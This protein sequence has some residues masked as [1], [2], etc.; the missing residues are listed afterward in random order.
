[1][2]PNR[3]HPVP[4]TSRLRSLT[5]PGLLLALVFVVPPT[6]TAA[7]PRERTQQPAASASVPREKSAA[8]EEAA[9]LQQEADKHIDA[10]QFKDAAEKTKQALALRREH[11]GEM[12][13]AVA[14][15]IGRLAVI[16]Y[17]QADYAGAET[18]A[19]DALRIRVA[20]LGP[21]HLDVAESLSDLASFVLVRGDYVQP[22]N[23]YQRALAIYEKGSDR[24]SSSGSDVPGLTADVLNNLALLYH[25]KGDYDRAESHYLKALAIT[26]STRGKDDP[27]VA[28]TAA[29][30]GGTY[31]ASG[32][33]DKAVE[34]LERALAIQEKHL[35]ANHPSL[36]TSHFN[37]AAVYFD[38][39]DYAKA[40]AL[41]RRALAIDE[42]TLDARHPRLAIRLVGLAEVLRLQ[43]QYAAADALYQRA[44]TIREQALGPSHPQVAETLIARS[45]L[46][47]ATGD[48][49]EAAEWLTRGATIR[50]ENL[51]LVLT[52]GSE[53]AKRLYVQ[54]LVDETD[55]AL[56]LHLKAAPTSATAAALALTNL[57]QRKGRSMDAMANQL[58]AVRGRLDDQDREVLGQLSRAQG[59]LATLVLGRIATDEQ[60]Q[61]ESSLRSQI[62]RLEGTIS[63][64]SVEFRTASRKATVTDIQKALPPAT[65]LIEFVSY[66]PFSVK[67]ARG[68]TF[69]AP[70]YAV[71]V[72]G[73][74]GLVASADLGEADEIEQEV[75]RF[76]ASLS[77]PRNQDVREA[78]RTLHRRL[79]D[80]ILSSLR[81]ADRILIA[82]DGALNLIPFAALLDDDG[83][84]LVEKYV[85]SYLTSGRD[86]LRLRET[87]TRAVRSLDPPTVLAN[88]LF[89]GLRVGP[90]SPEDQRPT[91]RG[92]PAGLLDRLQF[93]ALP[94]TADE[95]SA[96]A[97]VLTEARVY[98]GAS[99]T[100]LVLKQA[101]A[102]SILH[103][104]THGFFLRPSGGSQA[105]QSSQ[106]SA[107][108]RA[109]RQA[110]S[111]EDALLLSGLAL[112]GANQHWSGAGEDG[113]LTALEAAGLDLWGTRMVVLSACE[114]GVGDARNGE[115]V[116]GLR[117]ALV[118]AGSESQVMSLWQVSDIATRDL[119]IAY[120]QRLQA[121]EG[122]A[123]AL[124][125]V[126]LGIA[127]G[128]SSRAHP[129]FWAGFIQSGDWRALN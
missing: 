5:P 15:S 84:Y 41:F 17:Y 13:P 74:T 21:D 66:R 49:A 26:E 51:A 19:R 25:R 50:E 77:S 48:F 14:Y 119:M 11:L 97:T 79:I 16:A 98:T 67:N 90:A 111:R 35:P 99:A 120:Y 63:D 102:P 69:G 23:L 128:D 94:G 64:R 91:T 68:D 38:R 33:Y 31:Y 109:S 117:R 9:R 62:Q 58:A 85:V 44:L 105:S 124:R 24:R 61:A 115:G 57:L 20:A 129:F 28:E 12:D 95:A 56:S 76:R 116:Y 55:I 101:R 113:I 42:Q 2:S 32:Q 92:I 34:V 100:E 52:S 103:I 87:G 106:A 36:A 80:P 47:Y 122:R 93:D 29:N 83:T 22:E 53:E 75:R 37:L 54:T 81:D 65:C 86:L 82:P 46:R 78:A 89:D 3:S 114:T 121:G 108:G 125:K 112:A 123:D 73:S 104:A 127:H 72:L 39:G 8:L 96:L 30:L 70:R 6:L 7:L 40:E 118:L 10:K 27:G 4:V 71:Y 60:R 45:L 1:M 126:Q 18:F 88:P 43:G 107:S 110:S 59:Q